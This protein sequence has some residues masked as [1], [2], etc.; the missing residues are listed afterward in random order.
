MCGGRGPLPEIGSGSS[1][2]RR[3][4]RA[5]TNEEKADENRHW[6]NRAGSG[7]QCAPGAARGKAGGGEGGRP[8]PG[9][10]RGRDRRSRW[11]TVGSPRCAHRKTAGASSAGVFAEPTSKSTLSRETRL[12]GDRTVVGPPTFIPPQMQEQRCPSLQRFDC[13]RRLPL[14]FQQPPQHVLRVPVHH[15]NHRAA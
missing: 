6:R 5:A 12:A 1:T 3:A 2:P 4:T 7:V 15:H 9:Y 8:H 14:F 10:C 13:G 11:R